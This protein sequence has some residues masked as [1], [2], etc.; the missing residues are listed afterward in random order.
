M[1]GTQR[2]E[3]DAAVLEKGDVMTHMP[4]VGR[5]KEG[6][7]DEWIA[8][9]SKGGAEEKRSGASVGPRQFL[10]NICKAWG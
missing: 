5:R 8:C 4:P 6:L 10:P 7:E 2:I 3:L 1:D 9:E